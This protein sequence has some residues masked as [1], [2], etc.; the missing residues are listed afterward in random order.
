MGVNSIASSLF[1]FNEPPKNSASNSVNLNTTGAVN[2]IP[3]IYGLRRVGGTRL[4]IDTGREGDHCDSKY[5]NLV[6]AMA[7]GQVSGIT[8]VYID[9]EPA[10]IY[11]PTSAYTGSYASE[12]GTPDTAGFRYRSKFN[13]KLTVRWRDGSDTQDSISYLQLAVGTD[14][15]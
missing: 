12:L 10:A 6:F 9:S 5:L 1:G 7:E 13:G 11:D 2:A 4:F 14:R 8:W 15:A 3:V